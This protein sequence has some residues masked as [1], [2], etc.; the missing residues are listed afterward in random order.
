MI[1]SGY[2]VYVEKP[3]DL[4]LVLAY[5]PTE[6]EAKIKALEAAK[7]FDIDADEVPDPIH[8]DC[9][10]SRDSFDPEDWLLFGHPYAPDGDVAVPHG[11]APR[12]DD[13]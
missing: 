3:G 6:D 5:E 12:T 4:P 8:V 11:V 7:D 2:V 10:A 9:H 13:E 1:S